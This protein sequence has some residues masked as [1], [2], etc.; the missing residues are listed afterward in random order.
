ME[1]IGPLG[2]TLLIGIITSVDRGYV[3]AS[4]RTNISTLI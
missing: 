4:L 1:G 3:I 2:M